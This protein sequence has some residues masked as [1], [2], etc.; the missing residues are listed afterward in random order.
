MTQ[1]ALQDIGGRDWRGAR[2][3]KEKKRETV[4]HGGLRPV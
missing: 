3:T 1:V 4:H 2:S